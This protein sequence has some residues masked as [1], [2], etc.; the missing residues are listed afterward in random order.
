[1]PIVWRRADGPA[2]H[3]P[4]VDRDKR[5]LRDVYDGDYSM[6]RFP[7]SGLILMI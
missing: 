1:M 5:F 7:F 4:L 6:P 2:Q 3:L